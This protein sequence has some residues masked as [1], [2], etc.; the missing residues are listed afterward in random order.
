MVLTNRMNRSGSFS[1]ARAS[2]RS[3]EPSG[4]NSFDTPSW[5]TE[6][7]DAGTPNS[8][9]RSDAVFCD[10]AITRSA[11]RSDRGTIQPVLSGWPAG[12]HSRLR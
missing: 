11:L 7:R 8:A 5:T 9:C 1:R 4:R 12:N 3:S 6:I 10:T 2:L